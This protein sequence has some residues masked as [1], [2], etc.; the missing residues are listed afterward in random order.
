MIV[1]LIVA[2]LIL[3]LASSASGAEGPG[4][5]H[6]ATEGAVPAAVLASLSLVNAD[7]LFAV[8]EFLGA[9]ELRGRATGTPGADRAA[10][11]L[12]RRLQADGL[13]PLGDDGGWFQ[14]FPLHGARPRRE[15]RLDLR[16][17]HG[18]R[19]LALGEDYVLVSTGEG[20]HLPKWTPMVF[21]GYGV[22]APEYDY[23]DYGS[24]DVRG[25]IV[26]LLPG[27]PWAAGE[28]GYFE[29][30]RPTRHSLPEWKR[31]QALARGACGTVTLPLPRE[32]PFVRWV[33]RQRIYAF[34]NVVQLIDLPRSFDAIVTEELAEWL[35]EGSPHSL[36]QVLDMDARGAMRSFLLDRELRFEGSF[37]ERD[38]M[39][40]NVVGGIRGSDPLLRDEWVLV[41]AHYD[42]LGLGLPVRGDSLY[43][44]VVDNAIGCA[45]TLE[46][47]RVL[48]GVD[49]PPRRS[50]AFLFTVGEEKGLLGA[51]RW[52]EQPAFPLSATI[53]NVNV[54]GL[55]IF[56]RFRQV[57]GVG[58][59]LSTLGRHLDGVAAALDLEAVPVPAV[60]SRADVFWRSDQLA[61]ARAGIPSILVM[62]GLEYEHLSRI[63]GVQSFIAWGQQRYHLPSDDLS[64]PIDR[65]AAVQH[66]QVLLALVGA[67]GDT[68]APP[69]WR[70]S[71]PY[72]SARL[73][74]L[75]EGR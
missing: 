41:S 14:R 32:E 3:P 27:E 61:F 5:P 68:F 26:V 25:K 55:A 8:V 40:A 4:D 65:E 54:D 19:A 10:A 36:G 1:R 44:G 31:R 46:I 60:F 13:E 62:E 11:D 74:S 43:N 42:H 24:V 38:F 18:R 30:D 37:Q 52:C 29:G 72:A 48:A 2:L 23:D 64:Q 73:R 70:R 50:V 56:D 67:L 15:C 69:Q 9:D 49:P 22:V 47:A 6:P 34:E 28:P 39:A 63:E 53:A 33:D 71:S 35:L 7:S 17:A 66:T 12:A 75:A 20:T 57:V 45:A 21:A 51:R 59:E 16:D 58:A